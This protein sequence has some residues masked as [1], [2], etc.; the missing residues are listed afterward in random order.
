MIVIKGE[1]E[2]LK[3]EKVKTAIKSCLYQR[4]YEKVK[5]TGDNELVEVVK[6]FQA[7]H[8]E[9]T[10]PQHTFNALC[11]AALNS[12]R[13]F[14]EE[15]MPSE[16]SVPSMCGV[17]KEIFADGKVNWGRLAAATEACVWFVVNGL[18]EKKWLENNEVD[19]TMMMLLLPL[20]WTVNQ[21]IRKS[22]EEVLKLHVKVNVEDDS[23]WWTIGL[24]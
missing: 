3:I 5:E 7:E 12:N 8:G 14:F 24:F 11:E 1:E 15:G 2:A 19:F 17:T 10:I 13:S 22:P 9:E 21:W 16:L 20:S 4:V 23:W 18:K 6:R